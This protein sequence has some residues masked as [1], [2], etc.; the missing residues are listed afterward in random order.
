MEN[1]RD[2]TG[3]RTRD[4]FACNTVSQQTA[5]PRT[6]SFAAVIPK[7]PN[8]ATFLYDMD[9]LCDTSPTLIINSISYTCLDM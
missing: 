3:N 5:L 7:H 1:H 9:V 8:S 2:H 6:P 4:L